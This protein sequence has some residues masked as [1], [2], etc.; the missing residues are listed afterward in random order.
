MFVKFSFILVFGFV[1]MVQSW[2]VLRTVKIDVMKI[3]GF[4]MNPQ[5]IFQNADA[6]C[7][8][9]DSTL[10][11]TEAID[12]LAEYLGKK[13]EVKNVTAKAM[14]GQMGLR[15][16]LQKRLSIMNLTLSAL[17]KFSVDKPSKLSTGVEELVKA[18]HQNNVKVYLISGGFREVILPQ[19]KVLNIPPENVF[20]NRLMFYSDGTYA[21]IDLNEPTSDNMGKAKIIAHLK[22]KFGYK[23]VVMIGDGITDMEACPPAEICIGYGGNVVRKEVQDRAD[24]FVNSFKQLLDVYIKNKSAKSVSSSVSAGVKESSTT[25]KINA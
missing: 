5:S 11:T 7:L 1:T 4:P 6:V 9:V 21:G 13:E 15:E 2:G 18:L 10:C 24:W 12:E 20:A 14:S 23:N 25:A 19:A 22:E 16:A 17:Q 3:F 8:D